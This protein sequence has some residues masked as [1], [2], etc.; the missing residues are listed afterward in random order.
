MTFSIMSNNAKLQKKKNVMISTNYVRHDTN[1]KFNNRKTPEIILLDTF[2]TQQILIFKFISLSDRGVQ[3]VFMYIATL[4]HGSFVR[5][6][7]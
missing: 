4:K 1:A 6:I 2:L 5:L 7:P 3:F